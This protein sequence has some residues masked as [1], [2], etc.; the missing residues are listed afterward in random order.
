MS[1]AID[2]GLRSV[3]A[4]AQ[5]W[6]DAAPLD[7]VTLPGG[8]AELRG[9]HGE[10]TLR[11]A[12]RRHVGGGFAALTVAAIDDDRGLLRGATLIGLPEPATLAPVLGV[13]LIGFAGALS[14]VAV[15]LSPTD[16]T[17]WAAQAAPLLARLHAAVG[18]HVVPRRWPAF[19]AQVFS[20]QALIVGVRRGGEAPVLA[21]VA[22]FVAEVEAVFTGPR[23]T[24]PGRCAAAAARV[25]AWR[26]AE[27]ANRREHDALAR[28]FGESDAAA[29]LE[30]LFG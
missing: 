1:A 3:L 22:E 4:A 26:R 6:I 24:D 29:Y 2:V 13:D 27:L 20:S 25:A 12:T 14:L 30:L 15:D 10:A 9:A 11:L 23:V 16:E 21:A 19:A 18:E 28:I 17:R 8:L 5:G 7:R